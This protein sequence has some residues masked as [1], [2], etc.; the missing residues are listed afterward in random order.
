MLCRISHTVCRPRRTPARFGSAGRRRAVAL[1][2]LAGF[3]LAV[4]SAP[5][6]AQGRGPFEGSY[7][8]L[9][10]GAA[11]GSASYATDAGCLPTASVTF[12][13][14]GGASVA[15]GTAVANSGTGAL[16]STA[17]SGGIQA[18]HSWQSGALVYGAEGDLGILALGKSA[19][20]SG[21][22]P[23]TF[24]GDQ[25]ALAEK[26]TTH[27]FATLRARLGVACAPHLLLYATGGLAFSQFKFSS[28]YSDNA[29]GFGF[30]GGSGFGSRTEIKAGWTAGGGAEWLLHKNWSMKAEYLYV[31]LGSM[32][33]SVPTSNTA[34]FT[35][36]MHVDT[37]LTAQIARLG[38]NY[39]F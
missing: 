4:L 2:A 27:W 1:A 26:M 12:C 11:W 30:P 16:S 25:Y 37:Q 35:Q 10:A 5:A 15:N 14:S 13:D 20:A 34:A 19:S 21:F 3:A 32:G 28:S 31:D 6:Q 39:R 9:N 36:T 24:L 7:V 8:G 33:V 23:V 17:F 29:V 18:G 38:L 22:F